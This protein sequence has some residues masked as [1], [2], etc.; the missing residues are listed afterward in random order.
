MIA[1]L[2]SGEGGAIDSPA[3]VGGLPEMPPSSTTLDSPGDPEAD[4]DADG[5]TDVEEWLHGLAAAV[6]GRA[7]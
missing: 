5:Y 6:E 3:D 2:W 7:P 1:Q 4:A